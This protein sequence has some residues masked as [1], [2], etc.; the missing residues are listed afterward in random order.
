MTTKSFSDFNIKPKTKGFIGPSIEVE[1]ILRQE[2][3]VHDYK[4]GPSKFPEKYEFC[5]QLQISY[6]DK[7]RVIFSGSKTL[8]EMIE[9]VPKEDFPFKTIVDKD[10]ETKR[11]FFK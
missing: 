6:E 2:I 4:I 9:Q 10:K 11:H 5:L 8:I 7:K 3:I 1:D